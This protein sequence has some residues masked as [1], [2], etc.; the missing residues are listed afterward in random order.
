M[1]GVDE[2]SPSLRSELARAWLSDAAS[3]HTA[4]AGFSRLASHLLRVGA[5]QELVHRALQSAAEEI[6]QARCCI[7]LASAYGKVTAAGERSRRCRSSRTREIRCS[8][9]SS[10]S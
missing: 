7:A 8:A 2:L 10:G 9:S 6:T 5:P 4:A 3:K 1:N